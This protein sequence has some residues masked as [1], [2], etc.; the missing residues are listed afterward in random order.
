MELGSLYELLEKCTLTPEQQINIALNIAR[1]LLYLHVNGVIHRDLRSKNVLVNASYQAK[2][3]DFGLAKIF[4]DSIK[5]IKYQAPPMEW[6]APECAETGHSKE[7]DIYS[8]GMIL[9][10]IVTN[11]KPFSNF[12]GQS[13]DI[14]I[15]KHVLSGKREAIPST[16]PKFYVELI[17]ACWKTNPKERPSLRKIVLELE[18]YKHQLELADKM[19]QKGIAFAANGKL[20]EAYTEYQNA[21]QLGSFKANTNIGLFYL[22]GL[23]GLKQDKKEAYNRFLLAA[24]SGHTRAMNNLGIM[25][26]S[27]D[28]IPKD[29]EGALEWF[30]RSAQRGDKLGTTQSQILAKT[31]SKA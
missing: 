26:S 31:R 28:G 8:F 9:W 22:Q 2:L 4:S 14:E 12:Q 1:G 21:V 11:K 7:T 19:Y 10:E 23:A 3:T 13:R 29:D 16:V 24:N 27:G 25:L 20:A 18:A 6:S 5:S 30:N 15:Y 17:Q